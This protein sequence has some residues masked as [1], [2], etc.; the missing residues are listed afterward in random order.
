MNST[1]RGQSAIVQDPNV[2]GGVPVFRGT[3]VPIANVLAS[4]TTGFDLEQ[5]REAYRFLTPELI[6]AA[7][8]FKHDSSATIVRHQGH[9]R[10]GRL[11]SRDVIALPRGHCEA[12]ISTRIDRLRRKADASGV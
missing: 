5:L 2:M 9:S 3:R 12:D 8:T 10:R 4:L 6:E 7:Q 11:I 1:S